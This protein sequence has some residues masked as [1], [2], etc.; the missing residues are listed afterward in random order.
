MKR[1]RYEH[2]V[3]SGVAIVARNVSLNESQSAN[4]SEFVYN[5]I[6]VT[7]ASFLVN[8]LKG[9]VNNYVNKLSPAMCGEGDIQASRQANDNKQNKSNKYTFLPIVFPRRAVD[10]PQKN[11]SLV[12]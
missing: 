11:V 7:L 8:D 10:V 3:L 1:T 2:K 6:S 9:S 12:K 5:F 4:I